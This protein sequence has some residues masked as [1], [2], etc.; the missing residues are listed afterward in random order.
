MRVFVNLDP[1]LVRVR[2][3]PDRSR[4]VVAIVMAMSWV[5]HAIVWQLLVRGPGPCFPVRC[6]IRPAT[7]ST[8]GQESTGEG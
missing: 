5:V 3:R 8:A 2:M 1:V 7:N 4:I 6:R